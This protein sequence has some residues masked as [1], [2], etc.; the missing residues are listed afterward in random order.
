[1]NSYF[2]LFPTELMQ[3][4][5]NPS[6]VFVFKI[7]LGL[8]LFFSMLFSIWRLIR[9]QKFLRE[10]LL[11]TLSWWIIFAL[12]LSFMCWSR[13]VGVFGFFLLAFFSLKELLDKLDPR[14]FPLN[15]KWICLALTALQ[16]LID[17]HGDLIWAVSFLPVIG[18]MA[19]SL[20]NV[21]FESI[22]QIFSAPSVGIWSLLLTVSGFSHLALFYRLPAVSTSQ[23][24]AIGWLVYFLF[25]VQFNDV[26]QFLSGSLFGR[27]KISPVLSPSKTWE[28]FAG[29]VVGTTTLAVLLR[30]IT[31]LTLP[32]S[33]VLGLMLSITGF[34][35]DLGISAI[36]RKI[37]IKNMGDL[38]PGHGGLLD[39]VDSVTLSSLLYFYLVY[40]WHFDGVPLLPG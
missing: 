21:M 14:E 17:L 2:P 7:I 38:I 27:H 3:E 11:R 40:Y 5:L 8:L 15:A 30:F 13:T 6:I 32:Q 36:K 24:G 20:Y 9:P 26:L 39:R 1:M 28:G 22:E 23:T 12:F 19:L 37:G 25:L 16:F 31:A 35:G 18:F 4:A 34:L 29:G 33:V 10:M